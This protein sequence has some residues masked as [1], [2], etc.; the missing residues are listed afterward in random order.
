MQ[1][2]YIVFSAADLNRKRIDEIFVNQIKLIL[3]KIQHVV[4]PVSTAS[5][6]NWN[7]CVMHLHAAALAWIQAIS[8]YTTRHCGFKWIKPAKNKFTWCH[9]TNFSKQVS[10]NS[11]DFRFRSLHA[12]HTT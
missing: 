2:H 6:G 8:L 9:F 10:P 12:I 3:W 4:F 1:M 7:M 11:L 5:V